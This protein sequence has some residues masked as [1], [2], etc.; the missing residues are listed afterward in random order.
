MQLALKLLSLVL[1][2]HHI[3]MVHDIDRQVQVVK[4]KRRTSQQLILTATGMTTC[5]NLASLGEPSAISIAF[6]EKNH[7]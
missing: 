4:A 5:P 6:R 2:Q 3:T 1:Q 7:K